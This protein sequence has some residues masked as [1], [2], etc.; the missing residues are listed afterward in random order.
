MSLPRV[1]LE[2]IEDY[3][4]LSRWLTRLMEES[5]RRTRALKVTLTTTSLASGMTTVDLGV[6]GLTPDDHVEV[7]KPTDTTD[8]GIVAAWCSATDV[9]RIKFH[10]ISSGSVSIPSE[11]YKIASTRI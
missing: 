3:P 4:Q 6:V 9:A 11:V 8:I 5:F 1:P 10:N 2:E 7:T